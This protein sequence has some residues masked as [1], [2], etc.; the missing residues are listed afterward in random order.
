[1]LDPIL[2][3]LFFINSNKYNVISADNEQL[4]PTSVA[5]RTEYIGNRNVWQSRSDVN[6]YRVIFPMGIVHKMT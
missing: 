6:I 2:L 1:M 3:L 4:L 5:Q